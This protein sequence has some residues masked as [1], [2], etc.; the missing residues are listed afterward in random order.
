M[1]PQQAKGEPVDE[2][3][4]LF[5]L[6]AILY[7]C[8]SGKPP[9]SGATAME[10]CAQVIHVAPPPP[11]HFNSPVPPELDR[12][13]LKALEKEP[14]GRYQSAG[15]LLCEL[16]AVCADLPIEDQV[17]SKSLPVKSRTSVIWAKTTIPIMGRQ[18]RVFILTIL[19]ALA[20]LLFFFGRFPNRLPAT[21]HRPSSD[22]MYWYN[23]GTRALHNGGYYG[24]S[25]ALKQ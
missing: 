22:A 20:I 2:R 21:P 23:E 14:D 12:I 3:S 10:I 25:K 17:A 9:F 13:I 8:V 16:R 19:A 11:S 5:S 6:G 15:E 1:S 7:E 24:A 4:D 18:P